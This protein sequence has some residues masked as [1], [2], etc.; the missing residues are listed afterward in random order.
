MAEV[1]K[2]W[3][4][5]EHFIFVSRYARYLPEKGRRETWEE[6]VQRVT[7]YFKGRVS[8]SQAGSIPF[9]EIEKAILEREVM[10]SM[11]VMMTAGPALDRDNVAGYNCS[12]L[13]ID[14]PRAFDEILYILMCGTGVGFSVERDNVNK[15]PEVAEVFYDTDTV[16]TVADSRIGWAKSLREYL[17][18]LWIGQVP[19]WDTSRLRPAGARLVTFGGRSSGPEPLEDLFRFAAE[20]FKKAAG[21]KLSSIECHDLVCKIAEVVVCGGVRRSALLSLSNLTDDRMREAKSGQ[22]WIDN[23]QR[24]IANNSVSYT[25]LP[26]TGAFIREWQAL[27]LSKSGERGMFYRPACEA[28]AIKTGR[29]EG[30]YEWG[31]NPCSEI[32]LRPNQFCNLTEVVVR[33]TDTQET[34]SKK[35]ELAT[36]LGTLQATLTDFRYLRPIWNRNTEDE[37]L[38]GVSFTGVLD[39]PTLGQDAETLQSLRAKAVEVNAQYA[40]VLKINPSASITCVKPSGT[41]SQLVNSASG[42]HPR[43][44]PYYIRRVRMDEKDPLSDF[45]IQQGVPAEVDFYNKSQKVF[46]FPI[47]SP[48]GATTRKDMSAIDQL[49]L[50][51]SLN[52]NWCEHKPSV[53]VYVKEHEWVEVAAYVY[54]NFARLSGLSFLPYDVGTYRQPPYEEISAES[55]ADVSSKMPEIAWGEFSEREDNTLG[56]R[57]LACTAGVCEL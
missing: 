25:E 32:I 39:H 1:T 34:L 41:V 14:H 21:R 17:A 33:A 13:P 54:A 37:S 19:K 45:L 51:S 30:G 56:S 48:E 18:L 5:Y 52:D 8:K 47:K 27:Y 43:Y 2:G 55:F 6:A 40:K 10:P 7:N 24:S 38:L 12:Y 49:K 46:S 29:R 20:L 4:A 53:T 44:A 50:W 15:L 23:P 16:V 22:W 26:D 9:A 11:R 57:E 3:T 31:T 36:I 28:Q 42:M 35:V